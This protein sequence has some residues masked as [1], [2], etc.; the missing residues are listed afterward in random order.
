ML[1]HLIPRLVFEYENSVSFVSLE[2]PEINFSIGSDVAVSRN[3]YPNKS[4]HIVCKKKGK[5]AY[6]GILIETMENIKKFTVKVTW[7]IDHSFITHTINYNV[8]D[9]QYDMIS[10]DFTLLYASSESLGGYNASEG[11]SDIHLPPSLKQPTMEYVNPYRK[12]DNISDK[13]DISNKIIERKENI[14]VPTIERGRYLVHADLD[15]R[16]P[17]FY[18]KFSA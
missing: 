4:H 14:S 12:S 2:I 18:D 7:S 5:K 16:F 6:K 13:V 15:D 8:I 11:L 17:L 10:D 9:S 3:P 1:I